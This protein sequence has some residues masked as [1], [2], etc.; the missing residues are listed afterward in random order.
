VIILI[1]IDSK[2]HNLPKWMVDEGFMKICQ[3]V[4]AKQVIKGLMEEYRYHLF[5][6]IY[7]A[8]SQVILQGNRTRTMSSM[9]SVFLLPV[10]SLDMLLESQ[11][12]IFAQLTYEANYKDQMVD[13]SWSQGLNGLTL[14]FSEDDYIT[15]G[16]CRGTVWG[17][18]ISIP[19][20]GKQSDI[21]DIADW[22]KS[23]CY[24]LYYKLSYLP[25][26]LHKTQLITVVNRFYVVNHLE[27]ELFVVQGEFKLQD[28]CKISPFHTEPFHGNIHT[29]DTTSVNFKCESSEWS[30]G[31][32]NISEVGSSVLYLPSD[33]K[34]LKEQKNGVVIHVE[35]KLAEAHE[36]CSLVVVV[37]KASAE[38][39][40][41][42]SIRN[43]SDISV[44]VRQADISTEILSRP[45]LFDITVPPDQW[46]PFG[47]THL[48]CGERVYVVA[49]DNFEETI[50]NPVNR[51]RV[52]TL[53]LLKAGECIRLPDSSG[54]P[55]PQGE[56]V[57]SVLVSEKGG[58]VLR[59]FRQNASEIVI[60]GIEDVWETEQISD[61][62]SNYQTRSL[63][64]DIQ[65]NLPQLFVSLVVDKPIRREFLNLGISGL[66][67]KVE[68][69]GSLA[70]LEFSISDF[71]VDNYSETVVYP[72]LVHRLD[73]FTTQY[74]HL[75]SS[76]FISLCLV[77]ENMT[78]GE[79]NMNQMILT[80]PIHMIIRTNLSFSFLM[81]NRPLCSKFP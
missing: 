72:V 52:A 31:C 47:W 71:Q 10:E 11:D 67:I 14:V 69:K 26:S 73:F 20:E 4:V 15:L 62:E 51:R 49:G 2:A 45:E 18:P 54:R 9:Y 38:G 60:D 77:I 37:W 48:D 23:R 68:T 59:I 25:G 50:R 75:T 66:Q 5:G 22:N 29:S 53:S 46:I 6:K 58:R 56:I 17:D 81:I 78:G 65:M 70:S 80:E 28:A 12:R 44:S 55:G 13:N 57:L 64:I 1:A 21:V 36:N 63:N 79:V 3:Q 39:G 42:L 32:V 33:L 27:E 74:D 7:E 8:G 61:I 30:L 34:N 19:M 40:M 16:V 35:V 24:Q 43:E 41:A 76:N